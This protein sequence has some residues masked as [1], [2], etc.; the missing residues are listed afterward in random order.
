MPSESD[1]LR[2]PQRD[3]PWGKLDS[4]KLSQKLSEERL[5]IKC[6]MRACSGR[7]QQTVLEKDRGGKGK[8]EVWYHDRWHQEALA[9]DAEKRAAEEEEQLW[10]I[11][12]E[13]AAAAEAAA[14]AAATEDE[15]EQ[16]KQSKSKRKKL[17]KEK[18]RE[19]A[20]AAKQAV[21]D[22]S[23]VAAAIAQPWPLPGQQVAANRK[24]GPWPSRQGTGPR[25]GRARTVR[26]ARRGLTR[27]ARKGR[28][29][30]RS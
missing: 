10:K 19:A 16:A 5:D 22:A 29:R 1:P 25:R 14:K 28:K 8:V 2:H 21:V 20:I 12:E 27:R 13:R 23:V 24:G 26:R 7:V 18:Q 4:K 9:Q 15:E 3:A 17:E 11:E 30:R 6:L